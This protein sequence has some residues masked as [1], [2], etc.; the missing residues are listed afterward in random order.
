VQKTPRA[1]QLQTG[2]S[3]A[4][5]TKGDTGAP[6]FS[7]HQIVMGP[8][9]HITG[10]GGYATADCPAGKKAIAGGFTGLGIQ[11]IASG[12]KPD[13][14]GWMAAANPGAQSPTL[15]V[16]VVCAYVS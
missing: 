15:A 4:T 1:K 14:T 10:S 7:G 12:A 2:D 8:S 3:G 13:G 11:V 9:V 16:Q 5:G 6:G